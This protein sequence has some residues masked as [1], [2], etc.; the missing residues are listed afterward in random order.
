[1][2]NRLS[3]V[4]DRTV[5]SSP[6][7]P[8]AVC[9]C[10]ATAPRTDVQD[11]TQVKTAD[12]NDAA[13]SYEQQ[14]LEKE[15]IIQ[16][17]VNRLRRYEDI[18]LPLSTDSDDTDST[19]DKT[20]RGERYRFYKP[21]F[22][23][24]EP[25]S[26]S[27][28]GSS[29]G[30]G[31]AGSSTQ[32]DDCYQLS[33]DSIVG[34]ED[35]EVEEVEVEEGVE[36]TEKQIL[37]KSVQDKTRTV[38]DKIFE[39]CQLI[40][41][42]MIDHVDRTGNSAYRDWNGEYQKYYGEFVKLVSP[43]QVTQIKNPD[44]NP[45]V[46]DNLNRVSQQFADT[47]TIYAKIIISESELPLQR[48][49][50]KPID[51][52]GV[53]G[54]MKYRVQNIMF[55]FAFDILLVEEP[56]MWMYGGSQ[57]DHRAA[58]KAAG[59]EMK[60]L[61]AHSSTYVEGLSYPMMA[62]VDYLGFRVVAMA[63]LPIDKTT[64]VYGSD[65]GGATVRDSDP[66]LSSKMKLAAER[67]NLKGHVTGHNAENSKEI[68]GPGD[69]E[70]HRGHDG[71]LYVVDFARLMPPADPSTRLQI[72]P[73]SVFYECLR[74]EIVLTHPTPLCS[75]AFTSDPEE[76]KRKENN[77]QVRAATKNLLSTNIESTVTIQNR[78]A[79][80]WKNVLTSG[81]DTE[82]KQKIFFLTT[83][84]H[85]EGANFRYL[86]KIWS[87]VEDEVLKKVIMSVAIARCAKSE[88][89]EIMRL[90]MRQVQAPSD[91]D[92]KGV[93]A[94]FLN[95]LIGNSKNSKLYWKRDLCR[96]LRDW[97]WFD[98][99]PQ[100]IEEFDV[101]KMADLRVLLNTTLL[102]SSIEVLSETREILKSNEKIA[103]LQLTPLDIKV[104]RARTKQRSD[105]YFSY[106]MLTM[107]RVKKT[108]EKAD[109]K[110]KNEVYTDY[111]RKQISLAA[112][113]LLFAVVNNPASGLYL[114]CWADANIE[115]AKVLQGKV[116]DFTYRQIY[117][118]I[119]R[120]YKILPD[121]SGRSEMLEEVSRLHAKVCE[122]AGDVKKRDFLLRLAGQA[123]SSEFDWRSISFMSILHD[124]I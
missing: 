99:S 56:P 95:Q 85:F 121:C 100:Q 22:G 120:S 55:K 9:T 70:G 38:K 36:E 89:R 3:R 45:D 82:T 124:S 75:D 23:M 35:Y 12:N 18:A 44:I 1:M 103:R 15:K 117:S 116:S 78:V 72:K 107:Q 30:S 28:G 42:N 112:A 27:S 8:P 58:A 71:R 13:K 16:L 110:E 91:E 105:I 84:I 11:G 4:D 62:L 48:K 98:L 29:M 79:P 113:H 115:L 61:E 32:R 67:L 60:G 94:R 19:I 76:K 64:L 101:H 52:G 25:T 7:V 14:L 77:D 122:D 37:E 74:P 102:L 47:A 111:L 104:I 46:M 108:K 106:G 96:Q 50:I 83:L 114:L 118:S 59:N 80:L 86:G 43:R 93:V 73:R 90:R 24:Y 34:S 5:D 88:L 10:N 63:V 2:G 17:L 51:I 92:F 26:I 109:M 66:E 68:Y 65:D 31:L 97:F 69:I 6:A 39:E 54:G 53:A 81:L 41:D 49:S 40:I 87:T 21:S 33:D 57:A 119:F 123:H 20:K